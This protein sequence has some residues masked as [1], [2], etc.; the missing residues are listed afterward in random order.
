MRGKLREETRTGG[1]R[2][3]GNATAYGKVTPKEKPL[4][5]L[6][7]RLGSRPTTCYRKKSKLQKQ[8]TLYKTDEVGKQGSPG[9]AL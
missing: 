9:M 1:A 2:Q 4:A 3:H 7:R 5:L 8:T 6:V